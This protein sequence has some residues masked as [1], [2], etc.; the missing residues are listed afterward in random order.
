MGFFGNFIWFALLL[1]TFGRRLS[2]TLKKG[3]PQKTWKTTCQ[4]GCFSYKFCGLP[5]SQ[6]AHFLHFLITCSGRSNFAHFLHFFFTSFFK[7]CQNR[8]EKFEKCA[9]S[10]AFHTKC[11]CPKITVF[12]LKMTKQWL[13]SVRSEVLDSGETQWLEISLCGG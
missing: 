9:K 4:T 6:K 5:L 8:T 1:L 10:E 7:R 13:F 2:I 3:G 11:A 12:C